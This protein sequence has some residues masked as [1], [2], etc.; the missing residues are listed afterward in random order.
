VRTAVTYFFKEY[1][2]EYVVARSRRYLCGM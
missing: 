1:S 2:K